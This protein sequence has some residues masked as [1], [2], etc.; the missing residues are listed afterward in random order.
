MRNTSLNCMYSYGG[1]ELT[2][3]RNTHSGI[4]KPWETVA[5]RERKKEKWVGVR[6][7]VLCLVP[8]QEMI[9]GRDFRL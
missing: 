2:V 1:T 6:R 8:V 7:G 9:Q 5:M 3:V 4:L